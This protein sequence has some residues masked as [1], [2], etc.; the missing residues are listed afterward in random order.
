MGHEG[1]QLFQKTSTVESTI[2]RKFQSLRFCNDAHH[3]KQ[4]HMFEYPPTTSLAST[5]GL[6]QPPVWSNRNIIWRTICPYTFSCGLPRRNENF[7]ATAI[8]QSRT[9]PVQ[10]YL[11]N[12]RTCLCAKTMVEE[13]LRWSGNFRVS[14]PRHGNKSSCAITLHEIVTPCVSMF[15]E[16]KLYAFMAA[17][18][19]SEQDIN[20]LFRSNKIFDSQSVEHLILKNLLKSKC[21]RI[22]N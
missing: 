10:S 3:F 18:L 22:R 11:R 13:L 4:S 19:Y 6:S 20:M 1:A 17:S 16:E 21:C 12:H 15:E 9:H 2:F 5:W 8:C 14:S 7:R